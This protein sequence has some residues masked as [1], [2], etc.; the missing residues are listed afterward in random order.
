MPGFIKG[1]TGCPTEEMFCSFYYEEFGK[2][3]LLEETNDQRDTVDAP[4]PSSSSGGKVGASDPGS[5]LTLMTSNEGVGR[6]SACLLWGL[7]MLLS[8]GYFQGTPLRQCLAHL[9]IHIHRTPTARFYDFKIIS[10]LLLK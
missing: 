6:E 10:P 7:Y 4:T 8:L 5:P 1:R 2:Q 9:I 3:D